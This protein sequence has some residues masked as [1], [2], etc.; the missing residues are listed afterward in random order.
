M[1]TPIAV[2]VQ[3]AIGCQLSEAET[4]FMVECQCAKGNLAPLPIPDVEP[5]GVGDPI[6]SIRPELEEA[7]VT[8]SEHAVL[9][10]GLE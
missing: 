9:V 7:E 4:I 6:A 5:L 2:Q 1:L 10:L 8:E 3:S